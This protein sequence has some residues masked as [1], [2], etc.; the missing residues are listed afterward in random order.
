MSRFSAAKKL[1]SIHFCR[2]ICG[3]IV[4]MSLSQSLPAQSGS[5]HIAFD[6]SIP[7]APPQPLSLTMGGVS[8]LGHR[9]QVNSRYLT[10]DGKPWL[11]VMG[12]F[13]FSRYPESEWEEELLKMKAAGV[14]IIAT[15][16]FWIHHEEIEGQFDWTG[17]RDLRHFIELCARHQLYAF[18]RIGPFAHGEVRNGGFPDWVVQA[19]PTRRNSTKYLVHVERYYNEIGRQLHGMLW[20]DSGPVI[21]VQLENEYFLKGPD[22]GA[23]HIAALKKLA[24]AAGLEVPLYTV[25]GWEHADYPQ[26]EVLPVFGVY[27]DEF[28]SSSL[29]PLPPSYAYLFS[30]PDEVTRSSDSLMAGVAAPTSRPQLLAEAGGGMQV[31]YHRRPVVSAED[32]AAMAITQLGSGANLYGYY[33]FHGGENPI[34]KKSTMQESAATDGVYDLPVISYD[35]R[36]PLSQYGELRPSY[37]QLK[38]IHYFLNQFGD[39]LAPM[40]VYRPDR[41]PSG[42]EDASTPRVAL[43]SDGHRGFLFLNDH[44]RDYP[45]EPLKALQLHI[46]LEGE[47]QTVPNRPIDIPAGSY[48]I[49]PINL[50]L[51]GI[52]LKFATAQLLCKLG[53]SNYSYFFFFAPSGI[54]S[55]FSFEVSTIDL[56][57]ATTGVTTKRHGQWEVSRVRPDLK[58][59]I[60]LVGK[61]GNHVAIVLLS[62]EQAENL[63]RAFDDSAQLVFSPADVFFEKHAI[64]FRATDPARLVYGMFPPLATVSALSLSWR[65]KEPLFEQYP[66]DV[67]PKDVRISWEQLQPASVVPLIRRGAYNALAPMDADFAQAAAW[68]VAIPE[69]ALDR[70]ADLFIE[71]RYQGDVARLYDGD[72]LLDD[73]FFDGKPWRIGLRRFLASSGPHS[74]QIKI[75]PL[76][77]KAQFFLPEE[78]WPK[79]GAQGEVCNIESIRAM[80]IYKATLI[81]PY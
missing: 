1:W 22:A 47:Q 52:N 73:N 11:P 76:Q 80:P 20:K 7:P 5:N 57:H 32:V 19:G 4:L 40:T 6:A 13:H 30:F 31:A 24:I 60:E 2:F 3:L 44:R 51:Y 74:F 69:H 66:L 39:R 38:S 41:V 21:G 16:V 28:W 77:K 55:D 63:W 37:R 35:F 59:A 42:P 46:K 65:K 67:T 75:T 78:A 71:V 12:E 58:P 79:F 68:Q 49:W 29:Q 53:D 34:G 14:Q 27:P 56:L 64:H 61:G 23:N 26:D 33:M 17:R 54:R 72:R 15:Y 48:A 62:E 25:T 70:L 81:S 50:D 9:L 10:L 43:R 36:A 8:P 45:L 18:V